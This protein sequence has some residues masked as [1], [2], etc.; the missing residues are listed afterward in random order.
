MM[1]LID[2]GSGRPGTSDL[3]TEK[4]IYNSNTRSGASLDIPF[5]SN[6]FY[7]TMLFYSCLQKS[8]FDNYCKLL[9]NAS[10]IKPKNAKKH[11]LISEL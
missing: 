4:I 9:R 3:E 5:S 8:A 11:K 1:S 7:D 6:S 10:N 2:T